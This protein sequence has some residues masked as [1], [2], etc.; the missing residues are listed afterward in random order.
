[1]GLDYG[2]GG[3]KTA[4]PTILGKILGAC[5]PGYKTINC[6]GLER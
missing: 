2:I 5:V 1:M 4:A 3:L 6:F